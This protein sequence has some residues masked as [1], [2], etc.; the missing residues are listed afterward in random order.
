[1]SPQDHYSHGQ[2]EYS[3]GNQ[4]YDHEQS[5]DNGLMKGVDEG[6]YDD[7]DKH[8]YG[9]WGRYAKGKEHAS[10]YG[11]E[12]SDGLGEGLHDKEH[13]AGEYLHNDDVYEHKLHD[14]GHDHDHQGSYGHGFGL[15]GLHHGHDFGHLGRG[16]R[17]H[18]GA[19]HDFGGHD[20]H[21]GHGHCS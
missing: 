19:N 16:F 14:H 20:D 4:G 6:H 3:D 7:L 18:H 10:Y 21:Y 15:H 13:H 1:T 17:H 9:G 5:Y 11:S 2:G 12:Y 8:K